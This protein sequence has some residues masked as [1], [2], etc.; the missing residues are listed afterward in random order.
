MSFTGDPPGTEPPLYIYVFSSGE[1]QIYFL[2]EVSLR[3]APDLSFDEQ[4]RH[5]C[6]FHLLLARVNSMVLIFFRRN[7][8]WS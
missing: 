1:K 3:L 6:R 4:G 5:R 8:L 2:N 7:E